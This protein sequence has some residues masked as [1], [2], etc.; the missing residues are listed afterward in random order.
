MHNGYP[1]FTWE[2]HAS[3]HEMVQS[4][5]PYYFT[6]VAGVLELGGGAV[7]IIGLYTRLIGLLLAG[8]MAIALWRAEHIF[9]DPFGVS[10]YELALVLCVGAFALATFG[11]GS[12]SLDGVLFGKVTPPRGAK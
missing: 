12:I 5:L 2:K 6:Y 3:M 1:K 10:H 9:T 4:G 8:E 11:A 7:L